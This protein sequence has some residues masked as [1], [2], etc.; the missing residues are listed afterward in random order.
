MP[1]TKPKGKAKKA[2]RKAMPP[3]P[4]VRPEMQEAFDQTLKQ[5]EEAFRR[6]AKL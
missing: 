3:P 1:M 5:H 4:R 2:R 6:L